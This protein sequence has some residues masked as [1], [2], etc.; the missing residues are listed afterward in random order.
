MTPPETRSDE[1][2]D[3]LRAQLDVIDREILRLVNARLE[4]VHRIKQR[5]VEAG[6]QFVDP[7]RER[8]MLRDL[9]AA[10]DGPLSDAGVEQLLTT[11]LELGKRDVYEQ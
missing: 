8:E 11:I 3:E 7:G 4:I 9:L 2:I 6:I 10:N 1:L 5:K